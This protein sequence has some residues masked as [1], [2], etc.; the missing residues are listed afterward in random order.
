MI[1]SKS[2]NQW[3]PGIP[4]IV[5]NTTDARDHTPLTAISGYWNTFGGDE[6]RPVTIRHFESGIIP[7]SPDDIN[8][9]LVEQ[10]PCGTMV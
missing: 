3:S 1:H 9:H 8:V 5:S 6:V 10:H 2:Q 4:F 7:T